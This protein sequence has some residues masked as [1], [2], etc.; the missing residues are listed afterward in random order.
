MEF[1]LEKLQPTYQ[2]L[3]GETGNSQAFEIA[4]K[5]GLHQKLIEKAHFY[6]Y[7]TEKSF[8]QTNAKE[9]TSQLALNR[10]VKRETKEMDIK[11]KQ[12]HFAC[13]R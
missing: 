13:G 6:T 1:D 9:D 11:R 2:L 3:L 5:L 10:Y 12:G 8:K 4:L 7:G